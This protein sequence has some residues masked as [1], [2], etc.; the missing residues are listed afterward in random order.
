LGIFFI[1]SLLLL[2]LLLFLIFKNEMNKN[3]HFPSLCPPP[4]LLFR[5]LSIV[6]APP[7]LIVSLYYMVTLILFFSPFCWLSERVISLSSYTYNKL[8][9]CLCL[10]LF[11]FLLFCL[12]FFFS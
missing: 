1:L 11:L 6:C 8:I 7:S 9:F 4:Q 10:S 12:L 5:K 3:P 2:L